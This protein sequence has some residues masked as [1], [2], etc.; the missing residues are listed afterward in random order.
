MA[1]AMQSLGLT[2]PAVFSD[3]APSVTEAIT[4]VSSQARFQAD[5]GPTVKKGWGTSTNALFSSR[6]QIKARG[7]AQHD[8]A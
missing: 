4:A 3:S 7:E 2:V 1:A 8:E 6:R 5:H